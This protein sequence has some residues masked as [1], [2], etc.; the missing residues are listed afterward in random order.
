M[1]KRL[2]ERGEEYR[3]LERDVTAAARHH[4][5]PA[6]DISIGLDYPDDIAW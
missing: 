3:M 1:A 5:C 2:G 6:E 4:N